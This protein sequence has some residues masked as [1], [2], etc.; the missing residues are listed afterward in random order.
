MKK[1]L[2][3]LLLG[4][5]SA[6]AGSFTGYIVDSSCA[7]KKAMWTNEKCVAGC[8]KRGD[9]LVLA[10]EEGKIYQIA[11]Q[12]KVKDHAAKKVT[13]NGTL[14]GDTISVDSVE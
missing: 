5:M 9:K 1:L 3:V 6:L 8:M 10:T 4:A 12:D 11:D 13:I 14:N 7:A 2:P